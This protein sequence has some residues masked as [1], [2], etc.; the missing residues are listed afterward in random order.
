MKT[1]LNTLYNIIVKVAR[2]RDAIP[3]N[4]ERSREILSMLGRLSME[5]EM[6]SRESEISLWNFKNHLI[7]DVVAE[8]QARGGKR[9]VA[10]F[11]KADR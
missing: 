3:E 9:D 1:N 8:Y 2:E 11:V 4:S 7:S 10:Q 6:V 5:D